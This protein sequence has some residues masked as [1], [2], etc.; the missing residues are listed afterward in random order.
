MSTLSTVSNKLLVGLSN[1]SE[2]LIQK[3]YIKEYNFG[4]H[5]TDLKNYP[6]IIV[7]FPDGTFPKSTWKNYSIGF[8]V[9]VYANVLL[10]KPMKYDY[11]SR[12]IIGEFIDSLGYVEKEGF[13]INLTNHLFNAKLFPNNS[14]IMTSTV[15]LKCTSNE[16][17][18]QIKRPFNK[19][20][21]YKK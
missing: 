12:D 15:A 17:R 9:M 16:C 14:Q 7:H 1:I 4:G 8:V 6:N 3:K 21:G 11:L 20:N 18:N 10:K 2:E 19:R 5:I 13:S